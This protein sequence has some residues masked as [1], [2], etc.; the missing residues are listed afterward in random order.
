VDA[1]VRSLQPGGIWEMGRD[2]ARGGEPGGG[3][4]GPGENLGGAAGVAGD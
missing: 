2:L 1:F 4:G 3:A